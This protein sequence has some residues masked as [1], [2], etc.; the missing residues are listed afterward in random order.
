MF[1]EFGDSK[2]GFECTIAISGSDSPLS[3]DPSTPW[4]RLWD[5][6]DVALRVLYSLVVHLLNI[7]L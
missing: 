2:L 3:T 5:C 6:N 1:G 7:S 4:R